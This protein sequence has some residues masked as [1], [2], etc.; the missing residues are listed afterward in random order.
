MGDDQL[1]YTAIG[2]P[3]K[4]ATEKKSED[5]GEDVFNTDPGLL[6]AVSCRPGGFFLS[7]FML[8]NRA[9]NGTMLIASLAFFSTMLYC[10]LL[11]SVQE[12]ARTAEMYKTNRANADLLAFLW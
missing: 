5:D 3:S 9:I 1:H 4:D 8:S 10:M 7:R 6:C 12:D 11:L 2:M